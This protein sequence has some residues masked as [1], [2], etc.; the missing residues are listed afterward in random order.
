MSEDA[1]RERVES[2]R[3]R[4]FEARA[5]RI[6]PHLD[7]K[8]LTDW[9]GL[10]I[11][12]LA[13]SG[14]VLER[15]EHIARAVRAARFVEEKL[16]G[17]NG[18]LLHRYRGGDS[19]ID[20]MLDDY[21]F[22]VWGLVELYEST[23]DVADLAEAVALTRRMDERFADPRGGYFMTAK[24]GDDLI[25]RAKEIYDGAIPSGNS[26]AMLN[27][28]RVARFTGDMSWDRKARG[29]GA[30]FAPQVARMPMA[31]A[32]VLSAVDFI[33]GPTF[34][35]VVV[36]A[37]DAADTRAM[38]AAV[39]RAFTPNKVVVFRPSAGAA[40]VIDIAPYTREQ[41]ALDGAATAYVCRN[42]AC[43]LPTTDA[44]AVVTRLGG[45]AP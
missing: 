41:V 29:V 43:D 38:L 14:R 11:A 10:M 39:D 40:A 2:I 23:F 7:D 25:V 28:A 17:K 37:K 36:G 42:F 9:N 33:F 18:T 45:G 5:T 19:S 32:F 35:V 22:F 27:L 16:T 3:L 24:G 30:A 13:R 44:A 21:A 15:P 1:L 12:A 6:R 26:V 20:G 4:L 31:H 8:V 34:E